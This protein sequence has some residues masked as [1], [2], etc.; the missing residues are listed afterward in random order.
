M[1]LICLCLDM[2]F[3]EDAK[4]FGLLNRYSD[5]SEADELRTQMV[6]YVK[7]QNDFDMDSKLQEYE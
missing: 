3:D 4:L 2:I 7:A 5:E 1:S 6:A